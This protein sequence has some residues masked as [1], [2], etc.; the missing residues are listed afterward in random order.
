MRNRYTGLEAQQH[1]KTKSYAQR[2]TPKNQVDPVVQVGR[3]KGAL[4]GSALA[5]QKVVRAI[6]PRRQLHIAHCLAVLPHAQCQRLTIYQKAACRQPSYGI[7]MRK[8]APSCL[9]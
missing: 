4:Q 1:L 3:N 6:C 5:A 8:M 9:W 7:S 2:R